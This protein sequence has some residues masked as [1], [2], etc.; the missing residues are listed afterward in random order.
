MKSKTMKSKKYT[1]N[2]EIKI[3]KSK[4]AQLEQ[5]LERIAAYIYYLQN[6]DRKNTPM[7]ESSNK[8]SK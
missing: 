1:V 7:G 4:V 3:L 8:T 5:A 2:Q 6:N